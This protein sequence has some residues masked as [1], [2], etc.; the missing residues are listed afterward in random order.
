MATISFK[1]D[2]IVSDEKKR[3]RSPVRCGCRE[4]RPFSLSGPR[5]CRRMPVPYGSSAARNN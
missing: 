2:L 4:I 1:E 3:K 5:S